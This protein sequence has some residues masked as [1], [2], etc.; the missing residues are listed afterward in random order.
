MSVS[1]SMQGDVV[2]IPEGWD[3]KPL[4]SI[5]TFKNGI[6]K[7]SAAFG[8]GSGFVN[9]MDVFGVN[10]L[11]STDMLGLLDTTR[12]E[13]DKYNLKR[14]DVLFVRSS[15]K[16]SGVGLTCVIEADLP[17]TVFSGFLLRFRDDNVLDIGF[18]RHCFY[19]QTFRHALIAA[20]SI[21]ANTNINQ[22][23]LK[24]L[25]VAFPQSLAEQ[26]AIA[27]ALNEVDLLSGSLERLIAKKR[28]IKLATM[29]QL[30]TAKVRL[31][32]FHRKWER[33]SLSDLANIS[34]GTQLHSS[35]S[36]SGGQFPH[37]NGGTS[38]SSF[39][40]R[41]NTPSNTIAIS[42]GGNSCGYV[43][44]V[45]Q[46]FWCGG[47][48][49]AV[50]PKSVDNEFL[51]HALKCR[52]ST[53]QALRV[54]S[55]LP[56]VQKSALAAFEIFLPSDNSEQSAIAEVLTH[57][58]DELALLDKKWEKVQVIKLGMMQQLLTGKVRLV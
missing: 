3:A 55:G 39:T 45:R 15:V 27:D 33:K 4:G 38:P 23:N 42:E 53:I 21:S 43:Q 11:A 20:S 9:L 16:P 37:F 12:A 26:G 34:K 32:G 6:N 47:H 17:K 36:S 48:C 40:E 25:V 31:A 14:G 19:E 46:P 49:Y 24:K 54:G 50:V 13:Q 57:M 22:D 30:V 56:N 41:W 18:K 1:V 2:V 44:L 10:H 35:D 5:G 58:D 8:H 28:D 7:S 51:F 29:Q 52:Q